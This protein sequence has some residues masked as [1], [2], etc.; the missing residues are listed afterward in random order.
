[1]FISEEKL[2]NHNLSCCIFLLGFLAGWWMP[3][4][5]LYSRFCELIVETFLCLFIGDEE[6]VN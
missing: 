5:Q 6:E 2:G 1:M 3:K 4:H